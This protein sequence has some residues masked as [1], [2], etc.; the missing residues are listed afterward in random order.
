MRPAGRLWESNHARTEAG[1]VGKALVVVSSLE[2][3]SHRY[4]MFGIFFSSLLFL[5][6]LSFRYACSV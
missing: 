1:R 4:T 5:L 6:F 3:R 2:A